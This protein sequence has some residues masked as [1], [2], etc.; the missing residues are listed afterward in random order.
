MPV[1]ARVLHIGVISLLL[2]GCSIQQSESY[3]TSV[4][5]LLDF[6]KSFAPFTKPDERAI[7]EV[8]AATK[9][10]AAREWSS[11]VVV[12]WSKI[13]TASLLSRPLCGP[14]QFQQT[15]IRREATADA[16]SLGE[17]L[18][19]CA[20]SVSDAAS[21][22]GE[23]SDYTDISGAIG[24]A[25]QQGSSVQAK[26]VL[27]I[28]SDFVEELTP[29]SVPVQLRLNGERVLLLYR[30]GSEK[31]VVGS[32]D[33]LTRVSRWRRALMDAGAHS[34]F[35]L[36]VFGVTRQRLMRALGEQPAVGTDVVVLQNAPDTSDP[37]TLKT[38][39]DGLVRACREWPPPVTIAWADAEDNGDGDRQMVPLE[40]LPRL[41]KTPTPSGSY[42]LQSPRP[43][44]SEELALYL[45]E[46]SIGMRRFWPGSTKV[47]LR[48]ALS[49]HRAAGTLEG[50]HVVV[51]LST[52]PDVTGGAL[53]A[54][55]DLAATR[56][57]MLAAPSRADGR[58]EQ[59]YFR[60]LD[61]WETWFRARKAQ[62]VCRLQLNGL[63]SDGLLNCF[64]ERRP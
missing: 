53:D 59:G 54:H 18:D 30:P 12:I 47:D 52:F 9:E 38:V 42:G 14:L 22:P 2:G 11:P 1:R 27:I 37:A 60:R 41:I 4:V 8:A 55:L 29:G 28:L 43:E 24:M 13:Q 33:V 3:G 17:R 7:R 10:L 16:S 25:A 19:A 31:Q 40:F 58:N 15:L 6:S 5:V 50:H 48:A 64:D 34:V 23:R 63:T 36:P 35:S 46:C 20:K 45:K 56:V 39:A 26:K 49:M 57:V 32:S 62:S 44:S 21:R 51:I 61:R